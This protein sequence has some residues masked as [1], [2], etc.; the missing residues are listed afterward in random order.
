MVAMAL[1]RNRL[2]RPDLVCLGRSWTDG[3]A[4]RFWVP[5]QDSSATKAGYGQPAY[6]EQPR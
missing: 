1:G 3:V 5:S 2:V 4:A 6:L